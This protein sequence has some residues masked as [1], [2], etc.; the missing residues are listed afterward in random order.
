MIPAL[1]EHEVPPALVVLALAA[2]GAF[3]TFDTDQKTKYR[4]PVDTIWRAI[5]A[6]VLSDEDTIKWARI[7]AHDVVKNVIDDKG[8][9]EN[10]PKRALKA[11]QISG[12][13]KK[14]YIEKIALEHLFA[15]DKIAAA[16]GGKTFI[17]PAPA[18]AARLLK[19]EGYFEA[20]TVREITNIINK[21][22]FMMREQ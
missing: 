22:P 9:P 18:Q 4:G 6:G 2:L 8:D 17:L 14:H 3:R 11:L 19:A 10:R 20:L 12:I 13:D 15:L 21:W 5:H 7:V 16:L 1:D